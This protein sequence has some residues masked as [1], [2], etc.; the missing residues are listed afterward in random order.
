MSLVMI[1][2]PTVYKKGCVEVQGAVQGASCCRKV[3]NC[4]TRGVYGYEVQG[5]GVEGYH[6]FMNARMLRNDDLLTSSGLEI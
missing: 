4:G 2:A 5:L 1:P 6:T 3:G